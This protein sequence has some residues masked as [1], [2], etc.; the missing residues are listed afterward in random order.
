[1]KINIKNITY[2]AI[3]AVMAAFASTAQ[4]QTRVYYVSDRQV[5]NLLNQIET[6][7]NTFQTQVDRRLDR[8]RV[9]GTGT[10]DSINNMIANFETATDRLRDNFASRNSTRA[11]VQEVLNRAIFVNRF[12]EANRLSAAAENS[13]VQIRTDLNTLAGF[14]RVN[15]NWNMNPGFP[16]TV[17]NVYTVGD[18]SVRTLLARIESRTNTFKIQIDRNLDRNNN[19]GTAREDSINNMIANFETATDRLNSNFA[20]RRSTVADVQEVLDRA[21]WVNSYV[22]SN[23]VSRPAQSSWNLIRT[24]LNTLAGYYRVATNWNS[25]SPMPGM[26]PGT[27]FG[28]FD[29]RLTGTYRLNNS[30]SD[31]IST[32]IDRTVTSGNYNDARQERMRRNLETRLASPDVLTLEKVGQ[33]VIVSSTNGPSVELRAD[34]TRQTETSEN[35]RPVTTTVT[36]TNRDLTI[37]REGDRMN[38]Y[39][40]SFMPMN[41]GQLKVERRIYIENQSTSVISTSVYDKTSQSPMWNTS[42]YPVGMDN[43]PTNGYMIPNNTVITATLDTLLSTRTARDGDRFSMTVNSPSQYSGAIIEGNV[44][45]ERSGVVS[46]RANLS[47]NFNTIRMLDGRTYTFA[48]YANQVRDS[49]GNTVTVDDEGQIRDGSQTTKTVTRAG[50]GA[51]LG[52]IIGAIAGGGSGA[53]IGAGVGAGAGAG[54]VI[55]QGRDNL[56]LAAGSQFTI[57]ATAPA[58]IG[59]R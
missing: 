58:N 10:E 35:G 51:L 7:T 43:R 12:M 19:D 15:T 6:R 2:F 59:R 53:A 56:E 3:V 34:G 47:L 20:S 1:M 40:V 18:S 17:G 4:A 39:T 38:D 29:T 42:T 27:T 50:I 54:T 23:R 37:N 14:Y 49:N 44:V 36:A 48:G 41:N 9:D 25:T 46:G 11:D 33:R 52:G 31:N 13:W 55:L 5:Q 45:G 22:T 16:T 30:L 8:S 32:I 26:L 24:D 57:T 28:S 21:V